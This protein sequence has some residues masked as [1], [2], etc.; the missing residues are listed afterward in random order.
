MGTRAQAL[1]A[2][3]QTLLFVDVSGGRARPSA[4]CI[5]S[6]AIIQ[7]DAT[8]CG[9]SRCAACALILISMWAFRMG[10]RAQALTACAQPSV[11]ADASDGHACPSGDRVC[12]KPD[13]VLMFLSSALKYRIDFSKWNPP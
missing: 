6:A 13:C 9:Y 11:F 8:M 12:P 1:A 2:C 4:H 3:A 7:V 5:C 10:T